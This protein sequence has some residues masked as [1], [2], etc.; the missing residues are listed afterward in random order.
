ML[1]HGSGGSLNRIR[2]RD[3]GREHQ[4]FT[5]EFLHFAFGRFQT[6]STARDQSD[7]RSFPGK[8]MGGC[9]ADTSGGSRNYDYSPVAVVYISHICG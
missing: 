4:R 3:I 7:A 6:I 5:S 9:A 2:V 1:F 8:G